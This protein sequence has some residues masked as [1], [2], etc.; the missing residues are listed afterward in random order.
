MPQQPDAMVRTYYTHQSAITDP[1]PYAHLFDDL[2]RD[3]SGL[4]ELV[5]GLLVFPYGA[6]AER[7]GFQVSEERS[8]EP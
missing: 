7:Y 3:L 2:P 1:H 6:W 4:M 8:A 5:Q